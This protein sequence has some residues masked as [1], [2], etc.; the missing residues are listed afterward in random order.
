MRTDPVSDLFAFLTG[1]SYGEPSW[2]HYAYW[3]LAIASL[4]I[5]IAA[6]RS[7]SGQASGTNLFRFCLRFLLASFWWQQSLWKFPTDTGGLLYWTQQEVQHPAYAIQG[8][9]ID[10][11]FIPIFQPFAYAVYS[12]E[13]LVAV[14]LFLGLYVRP[15]AVLGM[16]LI[17]NLYFGLYRV[18]SEW[19]WSY[20]FLIVMMVVAIVEDWGLSLG[21]DA[22]LQARSPAAKRARAAAMA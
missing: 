12:F 6:W 18:T 19:P 20:V 2:V 11:L 8:E 16:L 7:L 17:L 14:L 15:I 22:Y 13:V 3:L 4:S 21:L 1:P 9:I 5:A 10:K